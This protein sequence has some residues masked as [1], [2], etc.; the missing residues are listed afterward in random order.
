MIARDDSDTPKIVDEV[1][2]GQSCPLGMQPISPNPDLNVMES[3]SK[4]VAVTL[5]IGATPVEL[6][7]GG[8]LE[9][10]MG[11]ANGVRIY[12]VIED[13]DTNELLDAE[14]TFS[15]TETPSGIIAASDRMD[16]E[17]TEEF[18]TTA[19][20]DGIAQTDAVATFT[21]DDLTDVDGAYRI[22]I[23][24][25]VG[26][27]DLGTVI[28]KREGDPET[29]VAGVFNAVCFM[30]VGDDADDYFASFNDKNEGCTAMGDAMR[31]GAGEMIFVK[32]HLEDSLAAS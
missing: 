13:K 30:P 7:D 1:E 23:E 3:R 11:A 8:E 16:E 25:M 12:A 9:I 14:V 2:L 31:F 27:L 15:A 6:L 21:L 29:I 20:V 18:G 17:D 32:A 19:N 5:A 28:L 22:T 26:S 24:L 4:L 10:D